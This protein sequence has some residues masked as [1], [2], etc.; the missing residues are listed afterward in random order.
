VGD[1]HTI[2][3]SHGE[4]RFVASDELLA[5][6]ASAGQIATQYV[7]G[8]GQPSM[9]L[10]VNPNG[11]V[12]AIEGITSPDGRVLGKMGHTERWSKGNFQNVPGNPYQPIF[13]GGVAYF[14]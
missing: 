13:E 2:A 8:Q 6:L 1:V 3:I 11:S 4:G 5:Q 14:A 7:D 9:D 12:L 10:A